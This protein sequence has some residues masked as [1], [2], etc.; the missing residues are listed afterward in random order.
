MV[1]PD[2]KD[3]EDLLF[4]TIYKTLARRGQPKELRFDRFSFAVLLA[5]VI[6]SYSIPE[7]R[8]AVGKSKIQIQ[9]VAPRL[10]TPHFL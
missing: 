5:I 6:K 8:F 2:F 10:H 9:L 1:L 7:D 3:L 4:L